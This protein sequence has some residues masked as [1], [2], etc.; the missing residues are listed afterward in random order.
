MRMFMIMEELIIGR[1]TEKMVKNFVSEERVEALNHYVKAIIDNDDVYNIFLKYKQ[2]F[3]EITP[4]DVFSIIYWLN[5]RNLSTDKIKAIASKLINTFRIGLK[6]FPWEQEELL[7]KNLL[8]EADQIKNRLNQIKPLIKDNPIQN[9]ADLKQAFYELLEI[10]KRFLKMEYI[11]FPHLENQKL[12]SRP[13]SVMWSLYDDALILNKKI[14]QLLETDD[15]KE[16]NQ[17]IG[18]YFFMVFGIIEKEELLILPIASTLIDQST[19]QKMLIEAK[20]YGYSFLN[21]ET[22]VNTIIETESPI[23]EKLLFSL[24]SGGLTLNELI[25]IL[26]KLGLDI[27]FVDENDKVK[28]YNNPIERIFPR[29]P[30]VIGRDVRKCHPPE[31]VHIVE[32]I[33]EHFRKGLKDEAQF[34]INYRGKFLVI[35]YYAIRNE[36]NEYQ[37]VLE[38]SQDATQIRKLEGENRLLQWKK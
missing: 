35:T 2:I 18:K 33:I 26:D 32:E 13:L 15:L 23:H 9:K 25:L 21:V 36:K 24:K 37:G 20:E 29:T 16:I 30:S 27:T 22:P 3:E 8:L 17:A 14:I 10:E 34:W 12:N 28:F 4:F 11:I 31:S 7:I 38:V 19:W 5:E 1:M 6:N